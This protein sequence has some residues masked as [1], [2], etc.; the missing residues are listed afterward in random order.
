MCPTTSGSVKSFEQ[1]ECRR[2][3]WKERVRET[4]CRCD[5]SSSSLVHFPKW[6]L[7]QYSYS[8]DILYPGRPRREAPHNVLS[9]CIILWLFSRFFFLFVF[10]LF[11]IV[12]CARRERAA[13]NCWSQLASDPSLRIGRR[14][15]SG[16][17]ET[18]AE[19]MGK[20]GSEGE[21]SAP[22]V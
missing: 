6:S 5:A 2:L 7:T 20:T 19:R 17:R 15:L 3:I 9:S 18:D 13:K 16:Q 11:S 8:Q 14:S 21:S 22:C 12:R 1:A 4:S 10:I